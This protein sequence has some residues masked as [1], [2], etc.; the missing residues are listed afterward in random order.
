[1]KILFFARL[2]EAFG[3]DS[4]ELDAGAVPAT[5]G[6]LRALLIARAEGDFAE[7]IGDPNVFCAVNQRVVDDSTAISGADE[8][9]FFPPMTGG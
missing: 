5:V 6:E 9:A 1:M 4:L 3:S 8:I 2:R 7:A